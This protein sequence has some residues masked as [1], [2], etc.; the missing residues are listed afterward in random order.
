[1][2]FVRSFL[3]F[4]VFQIV[5]YLCLQIAHNDL[6]IYAFSNIVHRFWEEDNWENSMYG[7]KDNNPV[8]GIKF[9]TADLR[10]ALTELLK[11]QRSFQTFINIV[12][13]FLK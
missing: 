4:T 7:K 11:S 8:S 9:A 13:C 2:F 5:F 3:G 6:L 12:I 10:G 1:M